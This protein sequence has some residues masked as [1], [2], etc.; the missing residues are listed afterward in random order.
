MFFV[1][2]KSKNDF[3]ISKNHGGLIFQREIIIL[4]LSSFPIG[5]AI[6]D[7]NFFPDVRLSFKYHTFLNFSVDNVCF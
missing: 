4:F 2:K 6:I 7:L 1:A 3:S 5:R